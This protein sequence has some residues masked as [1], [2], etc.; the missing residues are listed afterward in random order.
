MEAAAATTTLLVDLMAVKATAV[1]EVVAETEEQLVV[2]T[3][4]E[5]ETPVQTMAWKRTKTEAEGKT[6][7]HPRSGSGMTRTGAG[8]VLTSLRI[9]ACTGFLRSDPAGVRP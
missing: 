3:L 2:E 8:S 6:A 9:P 7:V 5:T 1:T 4:V